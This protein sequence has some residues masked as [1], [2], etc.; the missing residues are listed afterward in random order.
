M[1]VKELELSRLKCKKDGIIAGD[2]YVDAKGK[3]GTDVIRA[4]DDFAKK[5]R[6]HIESINDQFIIKLS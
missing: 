6:F 4:V 3:W 1:D 2:D 5:Y